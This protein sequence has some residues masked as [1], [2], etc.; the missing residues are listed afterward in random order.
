MTD[1]KHA[2]SPP[3]APR[4]RSPEAREA[5]RARKAER[6]RR[7]VGLLARGVAVAEIA[8]REGLSMSRTRGLLRES[9][10]RCAPQPPAAF[11]ATQVGRLHA[12]LRGPFDSMVTESGA[13]VKAIDRVVA[14]VRELDR[15][16]GFAAP[17]ARRVAQCRAA[18]M[19]ASTRSPTH[20]AATAGETGRK[21]LEALDS[22]L[23]LAEALQD[24]QSTH[25]PHPEERCEAS[26]LEG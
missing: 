6:D 11:C 7:V 24:P 22:E 25:D 18:L 2:P 10:A 23:E 15:F 5:A 4:D 9:L 8:E 21:R 17:T 20:S 19:A 1:P 14:I 26:R 3:S 12:A 16:H 13:N